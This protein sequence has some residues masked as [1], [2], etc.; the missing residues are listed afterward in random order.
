MRSDAGARAGRL[1]SYGMRPKARPAN[2]PDYADLVRAYQDD[3][4]FKSLVDDVASGLGLLLLEA[5][6]HGLVVAAEQDS[7]FAM[8]LGDYRRQTMSVEERLCHGL[9]QVAVAAWCFATAQ[10]LEDPRSVVKRL[11]V[12]Q[13]VRY[14]LALC[15]ELQ[16]GE[17]D[18][19]E[20]ASPELREAWRSVLTRPETRSTPDGRRSA[21]SLHGM[22]SYALERLEASGML[23]RV[24][25]DDG[26]TFRTLNAYKA[27][28]RELAAH[29]AFQL[30]QRARAQVE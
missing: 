11:S 19:Y 4:A 17:E 13:V 22:V 21:S 28:V 20:A 12:G 23:S 26:G 2:E 25:D 29:H 5:G 15:Q 14:L 16:S 18:D 3:A 10:E 9:I 6:E 24:S 1:I 7:V 30:L 27:Q 8:R